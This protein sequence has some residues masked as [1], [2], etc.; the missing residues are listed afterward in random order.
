MRTGKHSVLTWV[1]SAALAAAA[2]AAPAR[3][4]KRPRKSAGAFSYYLLALSWAPDFCAV[5]GN[6]QDPAE[7]GKGRKVGFVVHGLWPQTDQGT[8]PENCGASRVS[9][10]IVNLML[11]YIPTA[12]LIQHE[13]TTH[14]T[15]SGLSAADYFAAV[16]KARDSVTIPTDFQAPDHSVKLSPTDIEARFSAANPSFPKT[17]F[18][19]ACTNSRLQEARICFST[20]LAPQACTA[21]AGECALQTVTVLP[22]Q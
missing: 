16:R 20:N 3:P 21:S 4:K 17:A 22:V 15:C 9:Q 2:M 6:P 14:G 10:D 12:G 18:R 13:W 11:K 1:I 19:T 7:C 8:G 5:P